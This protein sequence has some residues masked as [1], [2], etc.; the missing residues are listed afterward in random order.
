MVEASGFVKMSVGEQVADAIRDEILRCR[1][2]PG[3]TLRE[4]AV[5]VALG[6]SRNTVREAL[7]ILEA[8]RLVT[9]HLHRGVI[10]APLEVDDVRDLYEIR[11]KLEPSALLDTGRHTPQRVDAVAAAVE[12]LDAVARAG[13]PFRI[14]EADL[15]FHCSLVGLSG[16][17]RLSSF[18]ALVAAE[19]RRCVVLVS[20]ADEEYLQPAPIVAQHRQIAEALNAGDHSHAAELALAH[21]RSNERRAVELVQAGPTSVTAI[22]NEAQNSAQAGGQRP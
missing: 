16:S 11:A 14:V 9:Y 2:M 3:S 5:A 8:E 4:S 21:V 19:V 13:D 1:R 6:V 20:L 18:F 7:R 22:D 17:H 10:V 12:N 15:A